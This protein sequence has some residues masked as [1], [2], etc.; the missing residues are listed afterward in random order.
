MSK[1]VLS[2][3]NALSRVLDNTFFWY[4]NTIR[5]TF[6]KKVFN[7]MYSILSAKSIAEYVQYTARKPILT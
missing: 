4:C 6:P 7:T 1:I 5:N 3:A 2:F